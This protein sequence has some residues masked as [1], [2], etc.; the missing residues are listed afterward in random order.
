[1]P[2]ERLRELLGRVLFSGDAVNQSIATLSGGETAR[3]LL[4]KMMLHKP[5]VLI[6]DEPTNH[7]DME[8]IEELAKALESY[9]GT[10]L[11]VSHNRYFVSRLADRI[12][13]ISYGGVKDFKGSYAEY[14]EK[15]QNDFLASQVILSKRYDQ[16]PCSSKNPASTAYVDH[17]KLKSLKTQLKKKAVQAEETCH[18][19]EQKIQELDQLMASEGFYQRTPREEQQKLTREKLQLEEQLLQAM[20]Q[21]EVASLDLQKS[22]ES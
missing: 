1:M 20:E 5:N 22:E 8:A 11:L 2:Q 15:Q 21:W 14:L 18:Q 6:F 7:L 19:F 16:D 4:A 13:E 17:K 12:I 9:E 10:L 3:L